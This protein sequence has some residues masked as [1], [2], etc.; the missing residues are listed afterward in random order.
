MQP[1]RAEHCPPHERL[2]VPPRRH[3]RSQRWRPFSFDEHV[4][5]NLPLQERDTR[6][7]DREDGNNA[8]EGDVPPPV[9]RRVAC[10][11]AGACAWWLLINWGVRRSGR[12]RRF[13]VGFEFVL[14]GGGL[15]LWMLTPFART[16]DWWL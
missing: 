13:A 1:S 14:L 9:G 10:L 3:W 11:C 4:A 16:W 8:A 12:A 7:D 6:Q 15:L 5:R 2:D